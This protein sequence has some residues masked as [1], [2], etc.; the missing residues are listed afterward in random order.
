ME[1]VRPLKDGMTGIHN[2][3]VVYYVCNVYNGCASVLA[4]LVRT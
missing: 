1:R 2:F 3:H 4:M